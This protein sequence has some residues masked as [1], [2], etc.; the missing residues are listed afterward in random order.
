MLA[1]DHK[2]ILNNIG[3]PF[4]NFFVSN[5]LSC[6]GVTN[7]NIAVWPYAFGKLG[8]HPISN[9]SL[10]VLENITSPKCPF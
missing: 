6:V 3:L 1:V 10:A 5:T 2:G 9:I 8:I 7:L 4:K